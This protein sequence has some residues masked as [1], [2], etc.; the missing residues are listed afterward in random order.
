[1]PDWFNYIPFPKAANPPGR[2]VAGEQVSLFGLQN[3][4]M[5]RKGHR[6]H[7]MSMEVV[8]AL[9]KHH[10]EDVEKGLRMGSIEIA[11]FSMHDA[12]E[13][14]RKLPTAMREK[15]GAKWAS[16]IGH[17]QTKIDFATGGRYR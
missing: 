16:K 13:L 2:R 15:V 17:A 12:L 6:R 1:M 9:L 5:R 8:N 4:P 14:L 11:R 7:A 3:P 10:L